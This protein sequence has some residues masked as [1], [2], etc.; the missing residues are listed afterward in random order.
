MKIAVTYDNENVFQ[1]FGHSKQ[2]KIYNIENNKIINEQIINLNENGH[3]AIAMLLAQ[4]EVSILICGG[5]GSGAKEA[6]A[7]LGIKIYA[8]VTGNA[9]NAVEA[10]LNGK[11]NHNDNI[12]CTHHHN[13]EH[14]CG[15][16]SNCK[17]NKNGCSGNM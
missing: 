4:N 3:G 16:H 8:G 6:L 17:E 9:R 15:S 2:I 5:I 14:E 13:K 10:L 11:L 1:H 7:N 12:T